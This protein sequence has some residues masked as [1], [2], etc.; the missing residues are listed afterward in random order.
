MLDNNST[1]T[2]LEVL[3]V[4]SVMDKL[5]QFQNIFKREVE[6]KIKGLQKRYFITLC[7][8]IFFFILS[9]AFGF[10]FKNLNGTIE[11]H[12]THSSDQPINAEVCCADECKYGK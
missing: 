1:K 10:F 3:F 12:V 6:K 7:F 8:V 5:A 11:N 2:I 4:S 9:I